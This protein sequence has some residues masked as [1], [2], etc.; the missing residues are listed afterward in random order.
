[1]LKRPLMLSRD[2]FA[3]LKPKA[4]GLVADILVY[5][6]IL[7]LGVLQFEC[8]LRT[9]DVVNNATY[10]DLARSLVQTGS[11]QFDFRPE[12]MLPPGFP[13]LLAAVY[14][15]GGSGVHILLRLMALCATGG[16]MVSYELLRRVEG[17]LLAAAA[18]LLLASAPDFFAIATQDV[19]SD[20][21]YFLI[22][23]IVLLV[24]LKMERNPPIKGRTGWI[25]I[26]GAT[27][28]AALLVR[29][30]GIALVAAIGTWMVVSWLASRDLGRRRFRY[31]LIPLI[32]GC[33]AQ[34]TWSQ[35]AS[36]R[37]TYE[38]QLGGWPR[39]YLSQLL[40]KDGNFP[41]HGMA[42]WRDIPG[43]VERN[44]TVRAAELDEL[45]LTREWVN[46]FW[47][48]PAII[49]VILLIVIGLATSLYN[50]GGQLHDWYFLWHEFMYL[51][52]PWDFEMRFLIPVAPLA[53]LY[54]WRGA[55]VLR[56]LTVSQPG[57]AGMCFVL[58]GVLL[59]SD[60][61]VVAIH[62][63][64][65]QP[66]AATLS[67]G[68]LA[69]TGGS[70]L[71]ARSLKQSP[72][73]AT[74][75][76]KLERLHNPKYVLVPKA[77]LLLVFAAVL[78]HGA[79]MEMKIG[80]ENLS[81]DVTKGPFYP[82]IEAAHW[83][84]A[85][86]PPDAVV[87]ARKHDLI[88]HYSGHRVIWFA[89]ISDPDVL[90]DGIRRHH[91]SL[92]VVVHRKDSRNTDDAGRAV[93]KSYWLPADESCFRILQQHYGSSFR[94]V[95]QGPDHWIFA[96]VGPRLGFGGFVTSKAARTSVFH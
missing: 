1:M 76:A 15:L 20:V 27:L 54:F 93:P 58:L 9:P 65:L 53:C 68:F 85:N 70:V 23:T 2:T 4:P 21:P 96:V 38:W 49:G 82:D 43:R 10:I 41:E 36:S 24:A 92:V 89:P 51:V 13:A 44:L 91:V 86:E 22:S 95:H 31:L 63:R 87:M 14:W 74:V 62:V 12:T 84:Q 80:Q 75:L 48:S 50:R 69:F 33:G 78:G 46:P 71:V 42:T 66:L 88:Y 72:F 83:I 60:S 16:I 79:A 61:A 17:R 5:V 28:S 25:F 55:K 90:M 7:V 40:V 73:F 64:R 57:I 30:I 45:L 59:G 6:A 52:W 81:Y 19:F 29:S 34:F 39:P 94:L 8:C 56:N 26:L 3:F 11:Y 32:L 35:W 47:G 18:C 77:A 37:Q 67:W